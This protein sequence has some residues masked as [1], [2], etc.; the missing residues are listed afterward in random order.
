MNKTPKK[1][2]YIKTFIIQALFFMVHIEVR[3]QSSFIYMGNSLNAFYV[4]EDNF[5]G[6]IGLTMD[7]MVRI[8]AQGQ[9]LWEIPNNRLAFRG[10]S[11]ADSKNYIFSGASSEFGGFRMMAFDC[12]GNLIWD[13]YNSPE[14]EARSILS[15]LHDSSQRQYVVA[16]SIN[17][18]GVY[19]KTK[20]WIAGIDYSGNIVW[21]NY[22][23]DSGQSKFFSRIFKN[24]QT[25]GYM[26]LS[27]DENKFKRATELISLDSLGN[28]INI[29]PLEPDPC[30]IYPRLTD[31]EFNGISTYNDSFYT[32][33]VKVSSDCPD[34]NGTFFYIYNADGKLVNRIESEWA[35]CL[36]KQTRD[37]GI[38]LSNG[39]S[40]TKLNKNFELE[41]SRVI[42]GLTGLPNDIEIN[43]ISQSADGGYFGIASGM[44]YRAIWPESFH[45]IIFKTDS[46][47]RINPTEEYSEKKQPM[48]LQPN[49]A[50][51]KVRI[52]IPYYYGSIY[53]RF[54]DIRGVLV[55]E[56]T[57]DEKI[58]FDIS[59]LTSGM[60]IVK[61]RIEETGET[62]TM[63]LLVQ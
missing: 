52:A 14:P 17:K 11:L 40:Y 46:L 19:D 8:N 54:Y 61:A 25:N 34:R 60:Y 51:D 35:C 22:W 59:S 23:R 62:R 33:T 41:W 56:K 58:P 63:K 6:L 53:A 15:I 28:I 12:R 50:Q 16:G 5:G 31:Y 26:L 20:Y 9:L 39:I 4:I 3:A 7:K 45:L 10:F 2:L 29:N 49:P 42:Q 57:L 48:M 36:I 18:V 38:I 43:E 27:K 13:K 47:G 24:P 55:F 37:K 32:A 44:D 1:Y 21:E 30:S